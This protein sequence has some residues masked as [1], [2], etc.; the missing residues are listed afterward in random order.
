ML[1]EEFNKFWKEQYPTSLPVAHTLRHDYA[2]RWFRIHS[3]PESKR[4][5][6]NAVEWEIVLNR[7]NTSITDVIGENADIVII[8]GSYYFEG[9]TELHPIESVESLKRFSFTQL[10][11]IDLHAVW[12][13]DYDAG[14]I[15]YPMI[16]R[17]IWSLNKFDDILRDVAQ[18]CVRL[19]FVS[20]N[21]NTIV[22]PYDGGVD[23]IVKDAQTM[24]VYKAM[25]RDW[26][27]GRDDGL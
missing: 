14:Q 15:F 19:F 21:T 11:A 23:F 27:S 17:A 9:H 6:E 12:P 18:D 16:A 22:V 20:I 25:Y 8:T 4:Y 2:S 10:D 13:D 26:L 7:Q 24:S 5:P 1:K 3:L